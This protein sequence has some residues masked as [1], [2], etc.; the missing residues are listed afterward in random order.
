[1]YNLIII[2]NKWGVI[3]MRIEA[4][5]CQKIVDRVIVILGKNI[6]IMDDQGIIIASGN[7]K[8]IGTFH[9]AAKLAAHAKRE[10]I[11]D[12]DTR[13]VG[14]KKGINLPICNA[15]EV[16]GV[17][18]ITGEPIEV[19]GYGVIVK[20]LVEMMIQGAERNK[21]ELYQQQALRN[22]A[23]EL[24]KEN[25][26]N[27]ENLR[28]RAQLVGFD[29]K[30][31]RTVMVVDICNFGLVI[32]NYKKE[33]EVQI[34]EYKQ[35]IINIISSICNMNHDIIFNFYEDRFVIIKSIDMSVEEYCSKLSRKLKDKLGIDINIGIGCTC[36]S[37]K[38]YYKSYSMANSAM[39]I[40]RKIKPEKLIYNWSEFRL[41]TLLQGI[42]EEKKSQFIGSIDKVFDD[43]ESG[44]EL[45]HTVKTYFEQ[46]MSIQSTAK[47]L[48]I[49]RNTVLYRL[50][51]LKEH[52]GI[53][54]MNSYNCMMLYISI[55][56]K[57]LE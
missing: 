15:N 35:N 11:V 49:H 3:P 17:I 5:E 13:F 47:A 1:V 21:A 4:A 20:E 40:G 22:L 41:E 26:L 23:I 42:A 6:N 44:K 27:Q 45:L 34:Q 25:A 12:T 18:G 9:E 53:D 50:N 29:I 28:G 38:D 46:G 39:K 52:C 16:I 10:I 32:K 54:I 36:R 33:T 37:I 7:E 55:L 43:G 14:C 56:L 30:I 57:E 31:A 19:K 24:I 2:I 8:R 48:Y 51:R